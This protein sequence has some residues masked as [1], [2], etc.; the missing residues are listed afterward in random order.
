[1]VLFVYFEHPIHHFLHCEVEH[2]DF[3]INMC[4]TR[5]VVVYNSSCCRWMI[6]VTHVPLSV[7][8]TEI[9]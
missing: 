7:L 5:H 9:S 1:M 6:D 4:I 3:L 2:D 8:R